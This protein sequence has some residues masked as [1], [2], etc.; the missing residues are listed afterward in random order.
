MLEVRGLLWKRRFLTPRVWRLARKDSERAKNLT[1]S[2]IFIPAPV[3][4]VHTAR[5]W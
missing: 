2:E 1:E 5:A 4:S 3:V